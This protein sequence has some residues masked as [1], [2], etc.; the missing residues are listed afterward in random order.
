MHHQSSRA[1]PM[2]PQEAFPRGDERR[3]NIHARCNE[4]QTKR[5]EYEC[6]YFVGVF[7]R[8]LSK[9]C[10]IPNNDIRAIDL[11]EPGPAGKKRQAY[12]KNPVLVVVKKGPALQTK[13]G[14]QENYQN[15]HLPLAYCFAVVCRAWSRWVELCLH[16]QVE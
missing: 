3:C 16:H 5:C 8:Y 9:V 2:P 7:F 13:A 4:H 11:V 12:K 14:A 15:A 6:I 10:F 1:I